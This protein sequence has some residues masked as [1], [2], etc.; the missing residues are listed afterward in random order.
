MNEVFVRLLVLKVSVAM[1]SSMVSQFELMKVLIMMV[2]SMDLQF[3]LM[4]VLT[5]MGILVVRLG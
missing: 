5:I 2:P 1:V 3:E 4:K